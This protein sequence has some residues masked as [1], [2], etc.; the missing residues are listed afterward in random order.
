MAWV[1]E[2]LGSQEP[3]SFLPRLC[4]QDPALERLGSI[5]QDLLGF[6]EPGGPEN[7]GFEE[8][9]QGRLSARELCLSLSKPSRFSS[10]RNPWLLTAP[11][12][13]KLPGIL[14]CQVC[15]A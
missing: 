11:K 7:L 14:N 13:R 8:V 1:P 4:F 12:S 15:R 10:T 9:L 3:F 5:L 6:Q 2:L